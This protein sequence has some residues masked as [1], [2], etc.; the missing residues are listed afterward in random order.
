M[1]KIFPLRQLGERK[2]N[3]ECVGAGSIGS[4][5][6][7]LPSKSWCGSSSWFLSYFVSNGWNTRC[8]NNNL[9]VFQQACAG[10][11]PDRKGDNVG[12]YLYGLVLRHQM[13]TNPL[14][15]ATGSCWCQQEYCVGSQKS[16]SLSASTVPTSGRTLDGEA[17][18]REVLEGIWEGFGI[19]DK[20]VVLASECANVLP[21]GHFY[22]SGIFLSLRL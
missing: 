6:L 2:R 15:V 20:R 1:G 12:D 16:S 21:P 11:R 14:R 13:P 7:L 17:P 19:L 10:S 9:P 8:Q 18:G 5:A 22:L 3:S 4:Q